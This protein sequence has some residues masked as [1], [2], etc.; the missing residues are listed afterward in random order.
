MHGTPGARFVVLARRL[1]V[2]QA[3]LRQTLDDLGVL[4]LVA[5]NPGYG[6]PARP[7][8]VLTAAGA[9]VAAPA[10][11]LMG[12]LEEAGLVDVGVRKWT[13][14]VLH[15]VGHAPARYGEVRRR[16]GAVTDRALAGALKDLEGIGWVQRRVADGYPPVARYE[17][18]ESSAAIRS[19]LEE[20]EAALI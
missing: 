7:E 15:A 9:R 14:P 1:G 8:Y 13:L 2:S 10:S 18:A 20:L 5:R 12:V 6:H 11:A 16:A 4:G 19:L 3:A 17:A